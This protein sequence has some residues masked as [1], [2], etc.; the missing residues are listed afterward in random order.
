MVYSGATVLVRKLYPISHSINMKMESEISQRY[1][2]DDSFIPAEE[3]Q[4]SL[5][6]KGG[7]N[8]KGASGK[9]KG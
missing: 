2:L 6:V 9:K 8:T 5:P 1:S 4:E 3:G 7:G